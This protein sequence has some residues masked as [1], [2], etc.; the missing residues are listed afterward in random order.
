VILPPLRRALL[1]ASLLLVAA[2]AARADT[3]ATC[4]NLQTT[5]NAAIPGDTITLSGTCVGQSFTIPSAHAPI[6]L[7][8]NA[9][10][11]GFNGGALNTPILSGADVGA[12]TISGL[13]FTNGNITSGSHAGAIEITGSA[14]APQIIGS[15]FFA[16]TGTAAGAVSVQASLA[17]G[18]T[19]I[20][21][22]TFGSATPGQGNTGRVGG[23]LVLNLSA[24]N[25]V[26]SGNDV[27]GNHST[28]GP[29]GGLYVG[30][31]STGS[32]TVSGN[33][34]DANS[35][36]ATTGDQDGGGMYLFDEGATAIALTQ[37]QFLENTIGA[38][39]GNRHGAGL[40]IVAGGPTQT[41]VTQVANG[42]DENSIAAAPSGEAGGA[43]EWIV[44]ARVDSTRDSFTSNTISHTG[45]EG[46]GVGVE[47]LMHGSVL[48]AGELHATDLV[49]DGNRL[50]V[51]GRGAGIYAG[52]P[53]TCT[54][55]DCP[56][57]LELFDSTVAGNCVDPGAGSQ[58]PGIAGSGD[59]TLTLRNS[60][61]YD[62]QPT[63]TCAS[64]A[65]MADIAGFG[66]LAL[67]STDACVGLDS[68]GSPFGGAGNICADPLLDTPHFGG[69]HES[70]TSPT[71]DAGNNAL[72]PAGLGV[73]AEGQ[74][75]VI[76]GNGDGTAAVDMGADESAAKPVPP[77]PDTT[78][79]KIVIVSK[80][81]R[82][83]ATARVHIRLQCIEQSH[84]G[85]TLT[86]T[87]SSHG[88]RVKAGSGR[89]NIPSN[90]KRT[91][92]I[93]LPKKVRSLLTHH[94][95][96]RITA[97]ATARDLA[98][99]VGHASKRVTVKARKKKK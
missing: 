46:A 15:K 75:R 18:T 33:R 45:G 77:V 88:K 2:P 83:S 61:V 78:P 85:G 79:P 96:I 55:A 59:D 14:S 10:G 97:K 5:L 94:T 71:I 43:G 3:P 73:D 24:G 48:L 12:T 25:A 31:F 81:V 22:N 47:G 23:A 17:S 54:I 65:P 29:G 87:T 57:V 89:F 28:A 66:G 27:T 82:E 67:A 99:N 63:L 74:P 80:T 20:Q 86:L 44:G 64:P 60:I 92:V 8:A 95:R 68:A 90:S 6:T 13:T 58:A 56:S 16:N 32:L 7:R 62:H 53:D 21:G 38:T 37:N 93:K 30:S 91:V 9:L 34:I 41:H 72:V 1:L 49:A 36:T 69:S 70:A 26:V 42:F 35:I 84:C 4:A 76:D 52:G 11:D 51:G 40:T 19:T 98:G 39:T 50:T